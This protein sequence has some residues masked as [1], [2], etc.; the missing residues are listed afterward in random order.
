MSVNVNTRLIR[1]GL[2]CIQPASADDV[3]KFLALSLEVEEEPISP[4]AIQI[5]LDE[6]SSQKDVVCVHLRQ[7]LYSLTR[8][9][10][11]RLTPKER[12]LRDKTRLFLLKELRAATLRR[13]EAEEPEK[14]DVS[15]AVF[16][17]SATQEERPKGAAANPRV[18]PGAG[19]AFWP[20][21]AKQLFVGSSPSASGLRFRFC[22][23]PTISDCCKAAGDDSIPADGIGI[24]EI[25]LG[26]GISPGL[27]TSFLARPERY[28]RV[29]EIPKANGK[30]RQ[31][32][33][34]RTMIKVLQYF[35][36]DYLL[37]WLEAHP[38]ATAYSRGSSI[39][40]NAQVHTE[41]KY[42][43]NIDV[44]NFFPSLTIGI[45]AKS[46]VAAGLSSNTAVLVA[47]LSSYKGGL[48]QGAPTSAALSNIVMREFDASVSE[49]CN[50][51]G[52]S[53]TRYAD[54]MTFSGMEL[55]G[56]KQAICFAKERL[57]EMRLTLNDQ[58]TR[59]FG[60]GTR[61]VVTGVVVNDWPQP[62]RVD[63][64]RLRAELH[65]AKISPAN[66]VAKYQQL[67]G[68]A[69]Y[70]L[71][72]AREERPV[73]AISRAYVEDALAGVK[74]LRHFTHNE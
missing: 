57:T 32:Q 38:T 45:V 23:F 58:K 49:S 5:I 7:R 20:L 12:H 3:S 9:G 27:L 11:G 29:F 36:L 33:A 43:A 47:R 55:D 16:I 74:M 70:M 40:K 10:D 69:A 19:R 17:D 15:S 65:Q 14:A 6:W 44:S 66:S 42:V 35:F 2:G 51:L 68:R 34:P 24:N 13:P 18:A 46:L 30:S 1:L 31:I 54:D 63:R 4:E 48:P 64:R 60:P 26:L 73:G 59:I 53:Y 50:S 21:L 61:Q 67:L 8:Q 25:S 22:S 52:V 41:K 37:N 72:Y 56:V 71:S 62:S 28:Y 39:R